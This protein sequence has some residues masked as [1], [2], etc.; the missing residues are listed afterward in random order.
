[1][2]LKPYTV[3]F[4]KTLKAEITYW[5]EDE[6]H[7]RELWTDFYTSNDDSMIAPID[8]HTEILELKTLHELQ[9]ASEVQNDN[10]ETDEEIQAIE[11]WKNEHP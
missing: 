3:K 8:E 9:C 6:D 1:M 2:N 7:A 10:P 5:A 4:K 11:A